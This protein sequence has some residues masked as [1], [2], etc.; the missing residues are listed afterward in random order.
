VLSGDVY[1]NRIADGVGGRIVLVCPLA[2]DTSE[3]RLSSRMSMDLR[4]NVSV[5]GLN[6]DADRSPGRRES[7]LKKRVKV[8]YRLLEP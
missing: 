7:G 4:D 5:A 3:S 6:E 2:S 8:T 1:T